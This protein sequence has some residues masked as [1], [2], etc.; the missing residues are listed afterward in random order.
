M[1]GT[2]LKDLQVLFF[3][4]FITLRYVLLDTLFKNTKERMAYRDVDEL[5]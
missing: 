1:L 4:I 3:K 5:A 2:L